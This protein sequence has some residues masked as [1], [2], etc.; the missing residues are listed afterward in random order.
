MP[1]TT[2]SVT[3]AELER[4]RG[5]PDGYTGVAHGGRRATDRPRLRVIGNTFPVP[6]V[7][8]AG[9]GILAVER[10]VGGG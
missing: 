1:S 10:V 5:L 3:P 8:W 4:L 2:A 6:M 9:E 7:R